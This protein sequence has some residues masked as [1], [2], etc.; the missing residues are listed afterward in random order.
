MSILNETKRKFVVETFDT[1]KHRIKCSYN[2]KK[3]K[4]IKYS[5]VNGYET[6][7]AAE[8]DISRLE[9]H[10]N[11]KRRKISTFSKD[12]YRIFS[13]NSV[14]TPVVCPLTQLKRQCFGAVSKNQTKWRDT[15]YTFF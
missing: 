11:L 15:K 3:L 2:T 7:Q 5:F 1:N 9:E 10:L 12:V 4:L 14:P 13:T 8:A 6:S